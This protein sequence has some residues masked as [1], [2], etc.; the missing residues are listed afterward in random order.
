MRQ[1]YIERVIVLS[2]IC[3]ISSFYRFPNTIDQYDALPGIGKY[4]D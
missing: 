1:P 2:D 3:I 4:W